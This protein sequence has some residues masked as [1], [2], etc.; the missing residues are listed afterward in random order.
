MKIEKNVPLP[1]HIKKRFRIGPLPLSEMNVG[2][3]LFIEVD[4]KESEMERVLHS[5]RVRLNRFTKA[6]PK[7]KFSASHDE[8]NRGLRVWR[9]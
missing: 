6:N 5:L 3:S 1:A 8:K 2:D 4:L 7:F 9:R